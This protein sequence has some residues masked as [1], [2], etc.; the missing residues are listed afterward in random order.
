MSLPDRAA[1]DAALAT[2]ED[3][4]IHKPLPELGMIKSVDIADDGAVT[5]EVYLTIAGCPLRSTIT[6]RVTSAVSAVAG[7]TAVTV[8]LD[9]MSD[10][11]RTELRTKLR[12]NT[13]EKEIPFTKPGSLTRVIA[14]ASGKGGV[15]KSSVTAN[16]AVAM[17]EQGL[18]VGLIDADIYGHSIPRLLGI[19]E[20][21]TV[22][23][24]MIMPT[25]GHG[26]RA[27]SMLPFKPG[28][29]SQPIA[30]RGPMLHRA[31]EQFLADVWWSDLDVLLLDMPPGTGD[32]PISIA[33]LLPNSE[34]IVV[35]TPQV[36]AAEVS[37][38]AGMLGKQTKQ[39]VIGVIENMSALA[40]PHCGE[41]IDLF[42]TGGGEQVSQA[43][44]AEF[45][46]DVPLLGKVPFDPKL[47]TGGDDG[48]PLVLSEPDCPAAT[49]LRDVAAS[50]MSKPRGLA[51]MRLNLT[52]Q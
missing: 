18:N 28:G 30:F 21:P 5:V 31:L 3:P 49:V 23:D 7:V 52:P 4:E 8:I 35:T 29:V 33:Q 46:H 40:C 20:K 12:G 42:G 39:R 45:G 38:R 41:P 6:E 27:I 15:G 19:T 22:V 2:V 43:L 34:I 32:I 50:L 1:I 24:G 48:Q 9:V 44:T 36:S 37:V 25:T 51:G 13:P 10:Q 11:Q 14:V 16:L 47:R 17:A 26:V